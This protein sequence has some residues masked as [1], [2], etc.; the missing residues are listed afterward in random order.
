MVLKGA[1]RWD[2]ADFAILIVDRFTK[3]R[4]DQIADRLGGQMR[5]KYDHS[6]HMGLDLAAIGDLQKT[7]AP[8]R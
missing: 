4:D 7:F 2:R 8:P 6:E 3:F 5:L 1:Q